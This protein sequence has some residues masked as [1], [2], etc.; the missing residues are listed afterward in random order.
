MAV[1]GVRFLGH[2]D[3]Q[4]EIYDHTK[5]LGTV[6]TLD[7]RLGWE[8]HCDARHD[9]AYTHSLTTAFF[10]NPRHFCPREA[11]RK[12]RSEWDNLKWNAHVSRITWSEECKYTRMRTFRYWR[13]SQ[14]G[15]KRLASLPPNGKSHTTLSCVGCIAVSHFHFY[16]PQFKAIRGAR[17][18]FNSIQ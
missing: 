12:R 9:F 13:F 11:S 17:S 7:Q 8:S 16:T 3:R 1:V 5:K 18:S 14:G 4:H 2:A 15:H 10:C 6:F